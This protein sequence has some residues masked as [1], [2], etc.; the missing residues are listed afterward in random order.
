MSQKR[1]M[2]TIIHILQE[3]WGKDNDRLPEIS[4]PAEETKNY[5]QSTPLLQ[6]M[7]TLNSKLTVRY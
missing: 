7:F 3:R 6:N 2:F 5:P 4:R 1:S